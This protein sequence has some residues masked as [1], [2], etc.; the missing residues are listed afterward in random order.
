MPEIHV[1]EDQYER[2][3]RLREEM[4]ATFVEGYGYVRTEDAVE[5]LLDSYDADG[6]LAAPPREES[7]SIETPDEGSDGNGDGSDASEDDEGA[8]EGGSDSADDGDDSKLDAMMN[9]LETHDEKWRESDAGDEKY[10]VDLPDGSAESART[11]D[12]VRAL[13]FKHWR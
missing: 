7:P 4:Q 2:L 13:L 9:L 5:Y 11:K 3:Q 8:E 10:E 1:T 6:G 12:D